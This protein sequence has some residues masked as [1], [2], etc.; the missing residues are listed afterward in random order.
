M[1]AALG[2]LNSEFFTYIVLP[3]L[4]IFTVVFAILEKTQLLKAKKDLHAVIALVFGLIVVGVPPIVGVILKL[5]P[6]IAV[7]IVVLL[8][9]MMTYGFVGGLDKGNVTGPWKITFQIIL[10]IVL[11]GTILWATG[12]WSLMSTKP[13]AEQIGPTLLLVGAIIA[14]ISVVISSADSPARKDEDK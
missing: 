9:W 13:W 12:A 2:L 11:I 3:F 5:V 14:V 8:A 1:A 7:I 4:L 6:V 10:S